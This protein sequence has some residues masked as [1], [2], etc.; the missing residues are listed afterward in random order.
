M[1]SSDLADA[2]NGVAVI[3]AGAIGLR[4]ISR[5]EGAAD[6]VGVDVDLGIARDA[7]KV[8][9]VDLIRVGVAAD[10]VSLAAG[11]AGV[12]V[13]LGA[14]STVEAVGVVESSVIFAAVD[15]AIAAV[16]IDAITADDDVVIV[17]VADAIF[18][19]VEDAIAAFAADAI[20]TAG[21]GVVDVVEA[22]AGVTTA[23]SAAAVDR[24]V[25]RLSMR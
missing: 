21:E 2:S 19:A 3:D 10:A 7:I 18:A 4:T 6:V 1:C 20:S 25:P 16:A 9:E 17:V 14:I 23:R 24:S 12:V 15:D 22:D 13:A 8:V 11:D 5:R